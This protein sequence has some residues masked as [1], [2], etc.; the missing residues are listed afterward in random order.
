MKNLNAWK[1]W[2]ESHEDVF[3]D[4]VRVYLGVGLFVKGLYFM[5]H[6]DDLNQLLGQLDNLAFSQAAIAHYIIPVHV[7]GGLLL[8]V[9][10]LTRIAALL[11][12]PILLG[13]V[14]YVY[15][16][17]M[18][19]IEPRQSLEFSALVLFL[20]ALIFAFGAGRFSVDHLL[21]KKERSQVAAHSAA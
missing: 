18:A 20:L 4:L 21:W 14:F 15:L 1:L 2:I 17:R 8:A 3:K 16:P 19:L 13:A 5:S 9:G 6:R 7:L 12:I 10:L 11:Q